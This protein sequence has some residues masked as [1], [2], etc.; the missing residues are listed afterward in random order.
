M[1]VPAAPALPSQKFNF[2]VFSEQWHMN[3]YLWCYIVA[4]TE[5][6][7]RHKC[8]HNKPPLFWIYGHFGKL[9]A[10]KARAVNL[11]YFTDFLE[12]KHL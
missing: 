5:Y 12:I 1:K 6:N 10:M 3:L 4:W 11:D 7:N 2:V 8:Y 9:T